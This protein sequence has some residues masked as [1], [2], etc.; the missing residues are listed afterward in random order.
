MRGKSREATTSSTSSKAKLQ[1]KIS[2]ISEGGHFRRI[3]NPWAKDHTG[4][5]RIVSVRGGKDVESGSGENVSLQE[6]NVPEGQIQVK[7]EIVITNTDW[8]EYKDRVY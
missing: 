8:L 7:E 3:E 5:D 1:H 2:N 4:W 6:M